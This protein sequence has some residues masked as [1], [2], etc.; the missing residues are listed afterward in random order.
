MNNEEQRIREFAYQIWQAEGQPDGQAE[1]HWQMASKLA[2]SEVQQ[3]RPPSPPA[4]KV[5]KPKEVP[6]VTQGK[7]KAEKNGLLK[8]SRATSKAP[9]SKA[10]K[11]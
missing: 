7:A 3:E 11:A 2:E 8:K 9:A 6:L 10:P 1:R 5:N 4:R